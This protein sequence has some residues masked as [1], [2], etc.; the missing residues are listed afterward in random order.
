[1]DFA[2]DLS[3]LYADFGRP[4]ILH[5]VAGGIDSNGLAILNLPGTAIVGGEMLATDLSLHY[6]AET[7]PVVSRGDVFV[8]DGVHY[9]VR[10]APQPSL[11]G[12]EHVVP[13]AYAGS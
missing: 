13:L 3:A 5:P 8:I 1:M 9:V 11:D 12:L 2:S 6:P 7:F 10:E 4:A